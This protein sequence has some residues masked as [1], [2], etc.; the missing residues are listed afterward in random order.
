MTKEFNSISKLTL[1]E[2]PCKPF[3]AFTSQAKFT[4]RHIV[5]NHKHTT[6]RMST[7]CLVFSNVATWDI[8]SFFVIMALLLGPQQRAIIS[9]TQSRRCHMTSM[10]THFEVD[11]K[12]TCLAKMI[13][14]YFDINPK[15]TLKGITSQPKFTRRHLAKAQKW[16]LRQMTDVLW[17]MRRVCD[18][19]K[20]YVA[21]HWWNRQS[22]TLLKLS[23]WSLIKRLLLLIMSQALVQEMLIR[24]RICYIAYNGE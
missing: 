21:I 15:W 24:G 11:V 8:A 2:I 22:L 9:F 20:T 5:D 3:K 13:Y 16:I 17:W 4:W 19:A 10:N 23:D 6:R 12:R 18:V 7:L 1:T 14:T